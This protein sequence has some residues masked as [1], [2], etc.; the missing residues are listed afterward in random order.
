MRNKGS[1]IM[2]VHPRRAEAIT[3]GLAFAALRVR[4]TAEVSVGQLDQKMFWRAALW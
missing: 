1:V 3:L 4:V 2:R